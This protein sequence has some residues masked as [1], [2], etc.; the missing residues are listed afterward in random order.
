MVNTVSTVPIIVLLTAALLVSVEP[1]TVSAKAVPKGDEQAIYALLLNEV[2]LADLHDVGWKEGP[3]DRLV[4]V[5][6]PAAPGE[7]FEIASALDQLGAAPDTARSFKTARTD[8]LVDESIPSRVP[9]TLIRERE[10][11]ALFS[12]PDLSASWREFAARYAG[13][14]GY[15]AMSGIGFNDARSEAVVFVVYSCASLCGKGIYVRLTKE[16]GAWV[17]ANQTMAW[18]S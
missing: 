4:I 7:Q 1:R 2:Y 3:G 12:D 6:E 16:K 10:L 5:A 9:Y 8:S 15:V 11:R 14:P 18:V 17:V 13:S